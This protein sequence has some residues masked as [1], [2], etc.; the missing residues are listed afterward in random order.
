MFYTSL[1]CGNAEDDKV[2]LKMYEQ[3]HDDGMPVD[4]RATLVRDGP[5]VNKTIFQKMKELIS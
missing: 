5:N 3:M 4:K 2:S 1:F